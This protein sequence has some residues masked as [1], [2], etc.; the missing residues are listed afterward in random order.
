VDSGID[1]GKIR[2]AVG[3]SLEL[4]QETEQKLARFVDIVP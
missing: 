3:S 4:L 1:A 2:F